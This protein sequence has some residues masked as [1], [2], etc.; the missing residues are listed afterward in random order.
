MS[1]FISAR[2]LKEED[3]PDIESNYGFKKVI[4]DTISFIMDDV[5]NLDAESL[6][7]GI[8]KKYIL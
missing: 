2:E 8:Q 7:N 4:I 6:F 1:I 5:D 3:Y